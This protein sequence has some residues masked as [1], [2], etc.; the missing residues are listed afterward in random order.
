M[1]MVSLSTFRWHKSER[2]LELLMLF[3]KIQKGSSSFLPDRRLSVSPNWLSRKQSSCNW[4]YL[5]ISKI[6]Q[7][8]MPNLVYLICEIKLF[9]FEKSEISFHVVWPQLWLSSSGH[10]H[11]D[12]RNLLPNPILTLCWSRLTWQCHSNGPS[13]LAQHE[14]NASLAWQSDTGADLSSN[15]PSVHGSTDSIFTRDLY[16]SLHIG[17]FWI[18]TLYIFVLSGGGDDGL[19]LY[20]AFQFKKKIPNVHKD[21]VLVLVSL[22]LCPSPYMF[23]FPIVSYGFTHWHWHCLMGWYSWSEKG[24]GYGVHLIPPS[25]P[26]TH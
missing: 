24:L 26:H 18:L 10:S 15:N 7:G 20:T 9:W 4:C 19:Y 17:V 22:F 5:H 8:N 1:V 13:W 14:P 23:P 25:P 11:T 3:A 21:Q 2:H 16:T 6:S 12:F